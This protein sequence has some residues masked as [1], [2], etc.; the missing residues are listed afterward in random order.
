LGQK[1]SDI[2][3]ADEMNLEVDREINLLNV[4]VSDAGLNI[5]CLRRTVISLSVMKI[6]R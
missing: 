1:L 5:G 4:E 3:E 6:G 2:D